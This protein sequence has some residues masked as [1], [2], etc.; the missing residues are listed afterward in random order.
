MKVILTKVKLWSPWKDAQGK[1]PSSSG[2]TEV[3]RGSGQHTAARCRGRNGRSPACLKSPGLEVRAPFSILCVWLVKSTHEQ[4]GCSCASIPAPASCLWNAHSLNTMRR[5]C[6]CV[7]ACVHVYMCTCV[8]A[9]V[10]WGCRCCVCA[11]LVFCR[12]KCIGEYGSWRLT[13]SVLPQLPSH[14]IYW[15]KVSQ[16]FLSS[17]PI[18]AQELSVST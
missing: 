5:W 14:F 18:G 1:S 7:C 8:C 17:H 3:R 11:Y 6:F 4:N 10:C 15:G 9:C 13:L 12:H 2:Q 16:G